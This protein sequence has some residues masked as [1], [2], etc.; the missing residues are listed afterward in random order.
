MVVVVRAVM[1]G[2]GPDV[3]MGFLVVVIV[4]F[5]GGGVCGFFFFFFFFLVVGVGF[6][7]GDNCG[8][9]WRRWFSGLCL[10]WMVG[11]FD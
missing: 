3:V 2:F 5:V 8:F 10:D 1:V 7:Q 4:G 6:F 11:F 9:C